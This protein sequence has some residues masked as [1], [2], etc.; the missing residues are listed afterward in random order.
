MAAVKAKQK[1]NSIHPGS[2]KREKSLSN[3]NL[4]E[5]MDKYIETMATIFMLL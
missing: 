3:E 5:M 1:R 2:G 4:P